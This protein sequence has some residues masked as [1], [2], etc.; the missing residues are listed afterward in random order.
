MLRRLLAFDFVEK[1]EVRA[2]HVFHLLSECPNAL[3]GPVGWRKRIFVRGHCFRYRGEL[4]FYSSK[5]ALDRFGGCLGQ[6]H[7]VFRVL[8][9]RRTTQQTRE[10][11]CSN[12]SATRR[13][14]LSYTRWSGNLPLSCVAICRGICCNQNSTR[15]YVVA[16]EPAIC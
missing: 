5:N 8:R 3:E 12:P 10:Y 14:T 2:G 13:H 15:E 16:A 11:E 9:H 4:V 6:G 7:V 1:C